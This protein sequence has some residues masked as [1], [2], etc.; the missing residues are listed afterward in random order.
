MPISTTSRRR[1]MVAIV[2]AALATAFID[3]SPSAS[4]AT[5]TS[6][7]PISTLP[8]V[9]APGKGP[10][11]G[12]KRYIVRYVDSTPESVQNS[13][14]ASFGA[15]KKQKLNKVFNG[16]I[17]DMPPGQA[18]K[19]RRN[20]NVLWVEED[21]GV[22]ADPKNVSVS[23]R[24]TVSPT[25]SWG[26]DRIDQLKLPLSQSYTFA[27]NG[28]N[29]PV[30]VVDTG[31]YAAHTQFTGRVR[32][33]F[34][35]F[36]GTTVD[37]NGH[38]SHVA[39]TIAGS[40]YGVAPAAS[41]VAVRVL[42][43]TG[44]GSVSGVIAGLDW[45]V[46]DHASG[47]AV[48]NMSIG[49]TKSASLDSA[50]DRAY[51]DGI[52][53]VVAAG[54]SNVDACTTSPAGDKASALTV[55]ATTSTDARATYSNFGACL[56][57]FAPGSGITS[58]GISST[59]ATATMSGTSM[60]SPHV[61]G[62]AA[63]YLSADPNASPST[64]M[65][66]IVGAA[67]TGVVT[68]AGTLSPNRLAYADPGYVPTPGSTTTIPGSTTLP[69]GTGTEIAPS[70]PGYTGTPVAVA[71]ARSANLTWTPA[72][73][74]GSPITGHVVRVYRSGSLV[75]Q[76][77]VDADTTHTISGLKSGFK[78]TFTV[79]AMNGVGVGPFSAPSNSVVVVKTTGNYVKP[80]STTAT[81]IVPGSPTRIIATSGRSVSVLWTPA[82]NAQAQLFN[83]LIY[84]NK[85]VVALIATQATG[86]V[87][88]ADLPRGRYAARVQAVNEAGSSAVSTHR[89]FYIR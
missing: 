75:N 29:V 67:N 49:A 63:R 65:A 2:T 18:L 32:A 50:V 42:D 81:D 69:P 21:S 13:D 30:Y 35:Y 77:V 9:F 39:G 78:Y 17:A 44:S 86:G 62:L 51:A 66:A 71:G 82:K 20:S 7:T 22:K 73:D 5:T 74:G 88:I 31:I 4:A 43:C 25:A 26:L 57:L 10:G 24:A 61:A 15:D 84:Q 55:G 83:V 12:K 72:V 1:A 47:P 76:V 79:A 85:K 36:G 8:P 28:V 23:A 48:V 19:L 54:N 45:V 56:D 80:Q 46:N 38:G 87:R 27:T 33:G 37:C 58:V 11:T 89:V 34:D 52:T 16:V 14:L 60:A 64:V 6:T 41:L 59:S 53:V 40:S 68:N 3:A 70:V